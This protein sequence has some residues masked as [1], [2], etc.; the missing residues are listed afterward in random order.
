MRGRDSEVVGVGQHDCQVLQY[1][2]AWGYARREEGGGVTGRPH[3][4]AA[5]PPAGALRPP[6][7]TDVTTIDVSGAEDAAVPIGTEPDE[8][9]RPK[10]PKPPKYGCLVQA[11][12][13]L[14]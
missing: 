3:G 14:R 4:E 8:R 13:R 7:T 5:S 6:R 10:A 11:G 1:P 12:S 9:E 2:G